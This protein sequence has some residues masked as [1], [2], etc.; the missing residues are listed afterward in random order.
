MEAGVAAAQVQVNREKR[1][2]QRENQIECGSLRKK[3]E[4]RHEQRENGYV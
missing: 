1:E 3:I 4:T 2:K